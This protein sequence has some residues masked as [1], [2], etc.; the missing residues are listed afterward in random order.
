MAQFSP[1]RGLILGGTPHKDVPGQSSCSPGE[2]AARGARTRPC[3]DITV[4][5]LTYN[6]APNLERTLSKLGWA[7]QI[8]IVDSFS[9]DKTLAIA[10]AHSRARVL[11]RPFDTFAAQCNFGLQHIR[12]AWVLSL[13][14]DYVLSDE[15]IDEILRLKLNQEVAGYEAAF[16]YCIHGRRLRSSLY[17]PRIVLFRRASGRYFDQGHS[18]HLRLAGESRRLN[19]YIEHDDRKPLQRWFHEQLRYSS[20]EARFLLETPADRLNR[21]DRLRRKIVLAPLLVCLYTLLAKRLLLD[22][23][24]GWYYVLQRLLSETLLSLQLLDL[25]LLRTSKMQSPVVPAVCER[26]RA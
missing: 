5:I 23:W 6:E 3:A 17:P 1:S 25:T 19:G 16:R 14:A 22:G 20:V 7:R 11:Q 9:T 24:R 2:L 4:L 13:D 15:L 12:T 8:L 26:R 18:H 10:H 21:Q